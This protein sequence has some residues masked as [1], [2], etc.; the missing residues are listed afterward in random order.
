MC[1]GCLP[2]PIYLWSLL[3][4]HP[5]SPIVSNYLSKY[6]SN[7]HLDDNNHLTPPP[8]HA[9]TKSFANMA[10]FVSSMFFSFEGIRLILPIE[11]SYAGHCGSNE[12]SSPTNNNIIHQR[13]QQLTKYWVK[14]STTMC[15]LPKKFIL[16]G[17]MVV[18]A[19]LFLCIGIFSSLAYTD[20]TTGSIMASTKRHKQNQQN[21]IIIL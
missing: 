4:W 15:C 16:P 20:T 12:S 6:L 19:V 1:D 5:Q 10:T 11:N 18:V 8:T 14:S 21:G 13:P 3:Y 17:S 7:N 2:L 9:T